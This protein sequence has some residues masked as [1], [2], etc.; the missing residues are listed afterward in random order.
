LKSDVPKGPWVRIPP[1][2]LKNFKGFR[3]LVTG[4][5]LGIAHPG[6]GSTGDLIPT[7]IPK[8]PDS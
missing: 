2:P 7:P 3:N 8:K 6:L 5:D 1:S 4:G